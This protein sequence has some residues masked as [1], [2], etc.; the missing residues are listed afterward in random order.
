MS[1][2]C[3]IETK[4][5]SNDM[6]GSR[7]SLRPFTIFCS[8]IWEYTLCYIEKAKRREP[9]EDIV[10]LNSVSIISANNN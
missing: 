1:P 9:Q 10:M 8:G 3:L 5:S 7:N 6:Y 2:F 4:R